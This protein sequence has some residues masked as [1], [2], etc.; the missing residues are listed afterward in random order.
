MK[1]YMREENGNIYDRLG[2]RYIEVKSQRL[3][4]NRYYVNPETEDEVVIF[5]DDIEEKL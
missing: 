5:R 2:R 4:G 1:R 3:I